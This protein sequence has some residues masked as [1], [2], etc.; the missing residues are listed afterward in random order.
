MQP[1]IVRVGK[2]AFDEIIDRA[3]DILKKGG[4]VVY[5]TDT[6]YGIGCDPLNPEA[7]KSLLR[8]K[9]R[10][11][12]YGVPL[13]FSSIDQC[14]EYHT[15]HEFERILARLFW[16]G[17]LTLVVTP[18][19]EIPEHVRGE[20][21]SIAVRVPDHDVPRAIA[22]KMDVP[23]VGT[24]ANISGGPSPF[25]MDVAL[26]QLGDSV[27]L[28][29]DGGES[30]VIKNSTIISI[31]SSGDKSHIKVHREGVITIERLIESL[32]VDSSA[33][34]FWTTQVIPADM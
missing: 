20:R 18:R 30:K 12:K 10:D 26:E 3:V 7:L 17:A 14:S 21:E 4:L 27:D 6:S 2:S 25:S 34:D 13:L 28:Y 5:P 16:P 11:P 23:I 9:Q 15:F 31:V 22:R 24:S 1:V 8:V 32:R 19:K 33:L 29:I